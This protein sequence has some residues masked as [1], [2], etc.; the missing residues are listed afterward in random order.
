MIKLK[1]R[2]YYYNT[3]KF[4]LIDDYEKA[5]YSIER[6]NRYD[7]NINDL[8]YVEF[9]EDS[10]CIN[11]QVEVFR[12]FTNGQLWTAISYGGEITLGKRDVHFS[13]DDIRLE[14]DWFLHNYTTYY[15]D[16]ILFKNSKKLFSFYHNIDITNKELGCQAIALAIAIDR[17]SHYDSERRIAW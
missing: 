3:L 7:Y 12:I 10:P 2:I 4:T 6:K 9:I 13:N 17:L 11:N 15:Q 16:S 8:C 1:H 14:R 5:R